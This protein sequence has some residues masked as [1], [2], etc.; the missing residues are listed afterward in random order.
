MKRYSYLLP[1]LLAIG[2]TSIFVGT[3]YAQTDE[4]N[5]AFVIFETTVTRKGVE[6]N[7]KNPEERRFY[8]SN[9][10]AIPSAD[11]SVFRRASKT[12][13]EYF[14]G[15]VVDPMKAKGIL[16]QY[17]DDGIR[18]NDNVVYRLDTRAEVEELRVKALQDLKEQNVNIFTFT[19]VYGEK[20]N[21]LETSHPTLFYREPKSPFYGTG[22]AKTTSPKVAPAPVR[23]P[24]Q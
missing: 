24:P 12:A 5:Y 21:G 9:V 2:I 22:E 4:P 18:I 14:T 10:V 7:D 13:D 15:T 17:Y 6:T 23:K 1:I 16:H 3:T 11:P 19:W 8:V 20:V